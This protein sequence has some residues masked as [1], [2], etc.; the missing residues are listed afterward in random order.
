MLTLRFK[1]AS[2]GEFSLFISG[3]GWSLWD[4]HTW[5]GNP[6]F[7]QGDLKE[8]HRFFQCQ[9]DYCKAVLIP[10]PALGW[11]TLLSL[12]EENWRRNVSL[13]SGAVG[14]AYFLPN[15]PL[16][17]G[18][19]CS[20][21]AG[22]WLWAVPDRCNKARAT[23]PCCGD[24]DGLRSWVALL[25][26]WHKSP[27]GSFAFQK[28]LRGQDCQGATRVPGLVLSLAQLAD[29]RGWDKHLSLGVLM[30]IQNLSLVLKP[31]WIYKMRV[32]C[33]QH[34]LSFEND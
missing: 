13:V 18:L 22:Y 2:M 1:K 28:W 8:K 25:S 29:Q 4:K 19:V 27:Q 24:W 12:V 15:L 6:G 7:L 30:L 20:H 21:P 32:D 11:V 34:T 10:T 33:S 23:V 9:N 26:Q 17:A 5:L 3:C 31:P 14:L 16:K